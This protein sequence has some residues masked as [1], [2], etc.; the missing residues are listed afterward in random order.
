MKGAPLIAAIWLLARAE[1]SGWCAESPDIS[2][3]EPVQ[4]K[5]DLWRTED[6]LPQ[7]TIRQLVQTREGYLWIGTSYGLA[8]YDGRRFSVYT[9]ELM[10]HDNVD[11]AI[12]D[13]FEDTQGRLWMR[14]AWGLARYEHGR[15]EQYNLP[16][17]GV[18]QS[19]CAAEN[20]GVWLSTPE[21][22]T[23][24]QEGVCRRT[25]PW[26]PSIRRDASVG[27][28]PSRAGKVWM[29]TSR[30]DLGRQ[31]HR[32]DSNAGAFLPMPG[33]M[34][35]PSDEPD[36]LYEDARARL[37]SFV[38]GELRCLD[39]GVWK[40][41]PTT[42]KCG[43]EATGPLME[44]H[45]G[46]IWFNPTRHDSVFRLAAGQ[47]QRFGPDVLGDRDIRCLLAD[48][49]DNIWIGTGNGLNRL[50]RRRVQSL[51][52]TN[53]RGERNEVFSVCAGTPGRIWFGTS[54]G[55][56]LLQGGQFTMFPNLLIN[57]DGRVESGIR[58]VLQD[59]SGTV[60]LGIGGRGIHPFADSRIASEPELSMFRRG[61]LACLHSF[62]EQRG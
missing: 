22:M 61:H 4:Y 20:G 24:F 5:V 45:S 7:N 39:A 9:R 46:A 54:S 14:L 55:L 28:V 49:E 10:N 59:R 31:W 48:R 62:P 19:A 1:V 26:P 37:W 21:G 52:A 11:P 47:F 38:P 25:Y 43:T 2:R 32:F 13:L 51:L 12:Q 50:R 36:E 41:F 34:R 57:Q 18:I 6:G 29:R 3:A 16:N 40:S 56:V 42:E 27:L 44:D 58:P 53:A 60:W 33:W 23:L 8:R 35:T 30:S 17:A 15:F